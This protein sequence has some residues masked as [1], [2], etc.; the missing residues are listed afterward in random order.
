VN[1][2]IVIEQIRET[3]E[4]LA[5]LLL[6]LQS[7]EHDRFAAQLYQSRKEYRLSSERAG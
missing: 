1:C 5:K 7:G 4:T 2:A 3:Q 6:L